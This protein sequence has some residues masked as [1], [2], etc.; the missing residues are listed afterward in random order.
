MS[1]LPPLAEPPSPRESVVFLLGFDFGSDFFSFFPDPDS[2][3]D[4]AVPVG[5]A[6]AP[7]LCLFRFF[8]SG[9][10][11]EHS[12][13]LLELLPLLSCL[14]LVSGDSGF[15]VRPRFPDVLEG[16]SSAGGWLLAERL[17]VALAPDSCVC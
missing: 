1:T 10:P 3:D 15:S 16:L 14:G 9:N 13:L 5:S 8:V 2:G 17:L 6:A 4:G 11:W 7:D 12:G